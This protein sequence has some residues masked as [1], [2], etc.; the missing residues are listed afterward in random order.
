MTTPKKETEEVEIKLNKDGLEP[1]KLLS[2]QEYN[3]AMAKKKA[4]ARKAK[5]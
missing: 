5:K 4:E 3:K 2:V 1:G